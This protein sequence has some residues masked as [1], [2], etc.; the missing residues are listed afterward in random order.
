MSETEFERRAKDRPAG[1]LAE[2]AALAIR[3]RKWWLVPLLI[4]LILLGALMLLGGS[5]AGPF[6]YTIF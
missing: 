2:L 6:I 5:A 3:R 1:A 4:L